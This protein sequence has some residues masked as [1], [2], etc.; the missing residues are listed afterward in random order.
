MRTLTSNALAAVNT[1][2]GTKPL[3]L[4]EIGWVDLTPV[5]KYA[6]KNIGSYAGR[7]ANMSTIDEIVKISG[8]SASGEVSVVLD[9]IAGDLKNI[10]D[11]NDI[12]LRPCWIYQLFD[13]MD[14]ADKFLLMR[15]AI[16]SPITWD[17]GAR[18]L[19]FKVVTIVES[20]ETG[21]SIEEGQF[22]LLPIDIVGK[23][24]PLAFGNVVNVAALKITSPR[25]GVLTDG[26][27]IHDYTL[28]RRIQ[29]A[30]A[31]CCPNNSIISYKTNFGLNAANAIPNMNPNTGFPSNVSVVYGAQGSIAV[32]QQQV[33]LGNPITP[34]SSVANGTVTGTGS[35]VS[36]V[37]QYGPDPNCVKT[38]C[39]TVEQLNLELT[40]QTSFEFPTIRVFGGNQF[41]QGVPIILQVGGAYIIG[42][43][44]GEIFTI[45]QRY[46]RDIVTNKT[47][48]QGPSQAE[49]DFILEQEPNRQ[50]VLTGFGGEN[51]A[52][53][54]AAR[55]ALQNAGP[56]TV[57]GRCVG[58]NFIDITDCQ[59]LSMASL[60]EYPTSSFQW[61]NAGSEVTY[62]FDEEIVYVA[63]ILPSTVK[64]VAAYRT[65]EDGQRLLLVVP[66]SY[67]TIR[68]TNYVTYNVVEVVMTKALSLQGVGWE[69]NIYVTLDSS[70]GPNTVD[71]IQWM[72]QKYTTF[73]VDAT[74][75][76]AV[77]TAIDNYPSSFA[78]FNRKNILTALDEI[79]M[80]ARCALFI[81]DNTFF[82]KYLGT[83]PTPVA[84]ITESHI[85]QNSLQITT[86]ATE[87]LVT[88]M[89][90]TWNDD[91]ALQSKL[92]VLR[93]NVNKYGLHE[94][95]FDFY[96]YNNYW[97]VQK[98]AIF[99][100]IRKSNT[101]RKLVFN[102]PLV[103]LPLE[104]YDDINL[105]IPDVAPGTF[106]GQ[107]ET[108][109][110]DSSNDGINFEVWTPLLAGTQVQYPWAYPGSAAPD[111][112]WPPD[113]VAQGV[114]FSVVAPVGHP[115]SSSTFPQNVPDD[116]T[117]PNFQITNCKG[118]PLPTPNTNFCCTDVSKVQ[119]SEFCGQKAQRTDDANDIKPPPR[120]DTNCPGA[121]NISADPV[122]ASTTPK[123]K[124]L[125]KTAN[126]AHQLAA[127]AQAKALQA[128]GGQGGGGGA[129]N[130]SEDQATRK[131]D[132]FGKVPQKKKNQKVANDPSPNPACTTTITIAWFPITG[133]VSGGTLI[134]V[135]AGPTRTETHTFGG[136]LDSNKSDGSA[137]DAKQM[138]ALLGQKGFGNTGGGTQELCDGGYSNS[139]C[140]HATYQV[141]TPNCATCGKGQSD[142]TWMNVDKKGPTGVSG[143]QYTS[144]FEDGAMGNRGPTG[145]SDAG[146]G[147]NVT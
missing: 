57:S 46:H 132:S 86:D 1:P 3:I 92:I 87:N 76:A 98:S 143:Q 138:L 64:C 115:L 107:V 146:Y 36:Q 32:G 42:S 75:F 89:I 45:T 112:L 84:T 43:F 145:T 81:R 7:I 35:G 102:T 56:G 49:L 140:C 73:G 134:C 71:I 123:F 17:E 53:A 47:F 2:T 101:W 28:R 25:K 11:N 77:R 125:L 13:G 22:P 34:G 122:F 91:Y 70:V 9:D 18:Q 82:I 50:A 29:L 96:I 67:Y 142:G 126:A 26:F 128:G 52:D 93:N 118:A 62:A 68:T 141:I 63:N 21:F 127:S 30:N 129:G 10:I 12:H 117:V 130:N 135:P 55:I 90:V 23:A 110:Y 106:L 114:G 66:P 139:P 78:M 24:W 39:D 88:R 104:P 16:N 58:N 20:K 100:M 44:A 69:D 124:A 48:T 37:P 144:I 121:L 19:S 65:L 97:L 72:I 109:T 85:T 131:N 41:R 4:L 147:L 94:Q 61:I 27:G 40:Q 60:N 105:T 103:M 108:A 133:L 6:D 80:Q 83:T 59:S 14:V 116:I 79:S 8:G 54:T 99:W 38:R 136:C 51:P 95:T 137:S 111:Q 120:T 15:G 5:S 33:D 119:P 31:I 113:V 74:T